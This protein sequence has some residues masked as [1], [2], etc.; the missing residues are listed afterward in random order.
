M[1]VTTIEKGE[2]VNRVFLSNDVSFDDMEVTTI[3]NGKEV[4]KNYS[5]SNVE[6]DLDASLPGH[7][8]P[9]DSTE[10]EVEDKLQ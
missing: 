1:E 3:E 5:E 10:E 7:V 8:V 4:N 6:V 9:E 2:E